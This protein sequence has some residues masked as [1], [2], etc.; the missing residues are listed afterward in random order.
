MGV[1]MTMPAACIVVQILAVC[2]SSVLFSVQV[3]YFFLYSS[4]CHVWLLL[5][6]IFLNN[7]IVYLK[8]R[9]KFY[10][11]DLFDTKDSSQEGWNGEWRM[12]KE[13]W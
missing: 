6:V 5:F 3:F 10:T 4:L 9:N 2:C 1:L 11:D 13:L 7:K 12:E 8:R